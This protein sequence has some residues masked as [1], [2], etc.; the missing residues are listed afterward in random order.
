[1][2]SWPLHY[3]VIVNDFDLMGIT[4]AEYETQP[5]TPVDSNAPL[6]IS[7]AAQF[8]EAVATR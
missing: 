6:I 1:M 2:E 3:S 7:I 4:G 5:K 8:L